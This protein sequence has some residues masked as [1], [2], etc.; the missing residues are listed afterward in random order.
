MKKTDIDL[1]AL[2]GRF[3]GRKIELTETISQD[4]M[5][6]QSRS[7]DADPA[8]NPMLADMQNVAANNGL[9]F[10]LWTPT[11][12]GTKEFHTNRVNITLSQTKDKTGWVVEKAANDSGARMMSL[13][14]HEFEKAS[15]PADGL[16]N[17]SAPS[18]DDTPDVAAQENIR[19]MR[20]IKLRIGKQP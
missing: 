10:R 7:L 8:K 18:I 1:D 3:Y 6:F 19:V 16:K 2:F 17:V 9:R 5:G 12:V 20:Q 4:M 14:P 13:L 15:A 11:T